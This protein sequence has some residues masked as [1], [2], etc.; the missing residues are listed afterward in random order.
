MV[1][2]L[3]GTVNGDEVIFQRV[4]GDEW[5]ATVPASLS[6]VYVLDMTAYDAAGNAAYW[7]RY[8]LTVDPAALRVQLKACPYRANVMDAYRAKLCPA[9]YRAELER[10]GCC[11]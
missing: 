10:G 4:Q 9:P 11:A 8:I 7:A 2:K 3:V 5:S 1:T 6:G